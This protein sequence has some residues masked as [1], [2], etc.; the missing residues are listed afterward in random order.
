MR[1]LD[2]RTVSH[3][4]AAEWKYTYYTLE[5]AGSRQNGRLW[6]SGARGMRNLPSEADCYSSGV[7]KQ[8]FP[9]CPK[10]VLDGVMDYFRESDMTM[11]SL[12]GQLDMS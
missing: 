11:A 6:W 12:A 1:V 9:S 8:I 2:S 7:A 3:G 10:A 5:E 4:S